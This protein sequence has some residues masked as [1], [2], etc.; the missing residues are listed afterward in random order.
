MAHIGISTISS[1]IAAYRGLSLFSVLAAALTVG[2]AHRLANGAEPSEPAATTSASSQHQPGLG[3]TVSDEAG[4][5]LI[6]G[7]YAEGPAAEAGLEPGEQ[8]VAINGQGIT[9]A[10]QLLDVLAKYRPTERITISV[11][12]DG[13]ARNVSLTL[14]DRDQVDQAPQTP[15]SDDTTD[16]TPSDASSVPQAT[17]DD[18]ASTENT[19]ADF[20]EAAESN[21]NERALNTDFD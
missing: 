2:M 4:P 6:T 5:V 19:G 7:T 3:I 11:S 8:I 18:G 21:V 13:E 17:A 1:R 10:Q 16:S 9:S 14:A 12:G 20:N 15:T